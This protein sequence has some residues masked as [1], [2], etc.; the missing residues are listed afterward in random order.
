MVETVQNL[1]KWKIIV[2]HS[3][4]LGLSDQEAFGERALVRTRGVI[5]VNKILGTK[6]EGKKSIGIPNRKFEII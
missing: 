4:V 2:F 6:T 5:N 3:V 1:S